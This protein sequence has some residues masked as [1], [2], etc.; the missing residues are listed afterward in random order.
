MI[1][2]Y[3]PPDYPSLH[4]TT[5]LFLGGSIDMGEA[6]DWQHQFV[7]KFELSNPSGDWTL[8]NPRRPDWNKD[9]KQSIKDPH[10][11]QQVNW[12]MDYL[13]KVDYRVFYFAKNTISPITLMELGK[14]GNTYNTFVY[15]D[16]AYHRAGNLEIFCHRGNIVVCSDMDDMIDKI[17][18]QQ[19]R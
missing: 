15:W 14:F 7:T 10:F 17:I 3:S 6:E 12:E 5:S 11:N 9:W 18:K 13:E 1:K 2:V 16:P 4:G 8:L 19:S